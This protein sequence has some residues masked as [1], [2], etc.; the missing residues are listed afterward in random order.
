MNVGFEAKRFFSNFTGLG[1][2]S[3]FVVNALSRY[4]PQ[5]HYTLF[6]PRIKSHPEYADILSRDNVTVIGPR[7]G[8]GLFKG[9]WR[10][11]GVSMNPAISEL[12]IYH[13]L[14]QELPAG[15]PSRLKKIVTVHD[16][17]FLR[18]PQYYNPID[19]AIYK[20]KVV[21]ACSRADKIISISE[22][23]SAD[24]VD[25]LNV[26][27][28]RIQ[29]IYQGC[30]PSFKEKAL[31]QRKLEVRKKYAL[32]EKY[33]LN[34][35]T[36]EPRKNVALLI[37]ALALL[38]KGLRRKVVI[39]GK[40]TKYK[41]AVTRI[42]GQLGVS[43]DVMFL[44]GIPFADLPV[45]YQMAEVFVYPSLFEGFGIP[46]LEAIESGVPVIS[47]TGSCFQEA[48]GPHALY[49]DPSSKEDLAGHLTK[50]LSDSTLREKMI[51]GSL[52]YVQRFQPSTIASELTSAYS[53]VTS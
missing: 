53:A 12:D 15:L 16:L 20:T 25:M 2:Y 14:S 28:E 51:A 31:E 34:V 18:F 39:V 5:H 50:V 41:E 22:Q 42:A 19:V 29:V 43:N 9:L 48:A 35:G 33:I 45:L 26:D 27:R 36:I 11:F 6:A 7:G 46:L 23:T 10:S 17:I 4:A 37:E 21:S 52:G 24:L 1:N 49:A 38:P 30:H 8:Y 47:S 40:S 44:H 3:R 32:P 13:G